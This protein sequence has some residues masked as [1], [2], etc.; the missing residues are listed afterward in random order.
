MSDTEGMETHTELGKGWF[1]YDIIAW[2]WNG[3]SGGLGELEWEKA[4][5]GVQQREKQLGKR[6]VM[7]ASRERVI[8]TWILFSIML[9]Y[10]IL[11]KISLASNSPIK[12]T[13]R[14]SADISDLMGYKGSVQKEEGRQDVGVGTSAESTLKDNITGGQLGILVPVGD[15]WWQYTMPVPKMLEAPMFQGKDMTEFMEMMESLFQRYCVVANKDKLVYLLDYCQSAIF[16]WIRLLDEYKTSEY[17]E[18]VEKLKDQY[19][20][21]DKAQKIF[22][23]YWL[24]AYKNIKCS[25][26]T[27]LK[28]Y[29]NNFHNM[30]EKLVRDRVITGYFQGLW[31]LQGL[32]EKIQKDVIR[33]SKVNTRKL[34]MVVYKN[35]KAL[36]ED[37]DGVSYT[38]FQL[39]KGEFCQEENGEVL[40]EFEGVKNS[41]STIIV[42]LDDRYPEKRE[43]GADERVS[44]PG[45]S[46]NCH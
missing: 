1:T 34:M 38:I 29:I 41:Q 22:N 35:L 36:V 25:E 39:R 43:S 8:R 16:I 4:L 7:G 3:G 14:M 33:Y 26:G 24:E 13:E 21:K 45:N 15:S 9:R 2:R 17:D 5:T 11:S 30:L 12:E 18:V 40:K 28:K 10:I 37:S 31:F 44:K 27:D 6:E 19:A 32:L 23:I 42:Q 20:A 46:R